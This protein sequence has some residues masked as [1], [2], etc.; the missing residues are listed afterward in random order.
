MPLFSLAALL[1][2][3]FGSVNT[4]WQSG[5]QVLSGNEHGLASDLVLQLRLPRAINAFTTGA[6][7][8]L[9]GALMQVLRVDVR[10]G[11]VRAKM[12]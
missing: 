11:I 9:A 2:Q 3:S 7:L 10:V 8:A 6:L 4:P 12:G 1:A 5:W